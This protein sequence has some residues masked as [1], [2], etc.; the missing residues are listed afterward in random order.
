V[1]RARFD[2]LEVTIGNR[3][4]P[5]SATK[6]AVG[7]GRTSRPVSLFAVV[8][9]AK[10]I[11]ARVQQIA[12]TLGPLEYVDDPEL[13]IIDANDYEPPGV[14]PAPD[15]VLSPAEVATALGIPEK[16]IVA[17]CAR[18]DL[19]ATKVG[20]RW[21]ILGSSVREYME[22]SNERV[23]VGRAAERV[24]ERAVGRGQTDQ[25]HV[26]RNEEGRGSVRSAKANRARSNRS[27]S[28]E[29]RTRIR[30]LLR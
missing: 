13:G 15:A 12:S 4:A 19:P 20:R 10:S 7:S 9:R 30:N 11:K 16:T 25:A 29:E 18:G 1:V 27:R 26:S 17:L 21:R 6:T 22:R 2:A 5:L 8:A 3:H 14:L 28:A 23:E 24:A